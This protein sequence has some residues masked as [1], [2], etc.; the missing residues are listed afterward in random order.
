MPDTQKEKCGRCGGCGRIAD[1]ESGDPWTVWENLPVGSDAA[2]RLGLIKPITCPDCNGTGEAKPK[3]PVP[4][5]CKPTAEIRRVTF[6]KSNDGREYAR[7]ICMRHPVAGKGSQ[8]PGHHGFGIG[9]PIRTSEVIR[10]FEGGFETRNTI[11]SIVDADP[12][13]EVKPPL[14]PCPCCEMGAADYNTRLSGGEVRVE[15]QKCELRT[16]WCYAEAEA[17][18]LWNRRPETAV[19]TSQPAPTATI[20]EQFESWWSNGGRFIDP[21]SADVPWFDKRKG[22]A[23]YA[24]FAGAQKRITAVLE[25]AQ[26][27]LDRLRTEVEDL[28]AQLNTPELHDFATG[29]ISEAQH[30]RARWGSDHDAGKEPHD[31]FWLLGYLA[32]KA[33][34][35][36]Q[37]GNPDKAL[38]HTISS[39][40]ALANW[41]AAIL[42]KTNMRP[43]IDPVERG[44][45]VVSGTEEK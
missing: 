21:D 11:Y 32:G 22:L 20:N 5:T 45:D 34:S 43:G 37:N 35:A 30:Q 19:A 33:L 25:T 9:D 15:C 28:R 2:V 44:V 40:A 27:E 23:G 8:A 12:S 24:F 29:V 14:L 16:K 10:H 39:A 17:R 41:H 13:P 36:H 26:P 4:E 7:G 3:A 18:E 38:H 6:E 31:W 1:N 42:G